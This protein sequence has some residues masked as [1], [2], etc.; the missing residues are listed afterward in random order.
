MKRIYLQM[1]VA[2][3][4]LTAL[5]GCAYRLAASEQEDAAMKSFPARVDAATIYVYRT[6]YDSREPAAT[7][8][9]D[10]RLI[11]NTRNGTYYRLEAVPARHVLH[12]AGPDSGE[13]AIYAR[14]GQ[15]YYVRHDVVGRQSRFSFERP[16]VAREQIRS[17]C[18]LL[19][20]F[21]G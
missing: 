11:G 17:C 1:F 19:T 21:G 16:D 4:A 9:M 15:I 12:G 18:V 8:Y 10:G 13:L 14:P 5:G 6:V 20:A 2:I 7:L 3:L